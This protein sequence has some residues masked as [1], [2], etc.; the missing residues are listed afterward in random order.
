MPFGTPG[1]SALDHDVVFTSSTGARLG[2][3]LAG[4]EATKKAWQLE[5]VPAPSG[6]RTSTEGILFQEQ[7]PEM[8]AAV[9]RATFTAG[10]GTRVIQSNKEDYMSGSVQ[11]SVA[12]KVIKS[13]NVVEISLPTSEGDVRCWESMGSYLY[14]TDGRYIHR[15]ADG[16]T[17]AQVHDVGAANRVS[18][19]KKYGASDADVGLVACVEVTATEAAARYYYS[20]NGSTW[21]QA[22]AAGNREINYVFVEDQTLFGLINSNTM[23]S[24]TD[25]FAAAA[26]WGSATQVGD[27][28][29]KFQGGFVVAGVAVIFKE[30]RVFTIDS[31]G[32]VATLIG[33][34]ADIPSSRNFH[35]FVAGWNSNIYFHADEDVWEYDPATGV[36]R[37]MGLSRLPDAQLDA[38]LT[39]LPGMGYDED[40]VYAIH[41]TNLAPAGTS[42][43]RI[44]FADDG[45]TSFERWLHQSLNVY[46]PQGPMRFTRQFTSL[47]TGRHMFINSTNAG[48]ILRMT[49]PRA[50]DPTTDSTSEY[51]PVTCVY[52][53]G[54]IHHNFPAQYKDYTELLLD[55]RGLSAAPPHSAVHVF[56]YLDNDLST[57]YTLA[58]EL[59]SNRL[60][61]L[62]F[63]AITARSFMLELELHSDDTSQTPQV[64]AWNLKASVK[65]DFREVLTL[66]VR[67]ADRVPNRNGSPSPHT[68]AQIRSVLREM[69]AQ[70]SETLA[71]KDYRGYAFDNVRILTGFKESDVVDDRYRLDE[72]AMTIRVMRV[73]ELDANP[74]IVDSSSV[75]GTDVVAH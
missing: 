71:Y 30:D 74:F 67:V 8:A 18:S 60:E 33:Q 72:T 48:K 6:I 41:Q 27:E 59:T 28:A 70:Q 56:Y 3:M 46:R 47:G 17:F 51:T 4:I 52:R 49:M 31:A 36:I 12:G 16:V 44:S 66:V 23:V 25:P 37:L 43:V 32:A 7:P 26:T 40:S 58:D 24:T 62:E 15:T 11:T 42:L 19:L 54:W 45:T 57:R 55:L 63:S 21:A 69:R 64:L 20:L 39:A 35:S 14:V 38:T 53:S 75:G 5:E 34:F 10:M 65:F 2:L 22:D 13:P 68:A 9:F 1:A 73:S 61:V 29:H 50:A